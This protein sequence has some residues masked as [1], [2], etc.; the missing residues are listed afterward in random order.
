[1]AGWAGFHPR[2]WKK[3]SKVQSRVDPAPK[4]QTTQTETCTASE[5][6]Q[7][8]KKQRSWLLNT[9]FSLF[10]SL[11]AGISKDAGTDRLIACLEQ[12]KKQPA[13]LSL[14]GTRAK[15]T[16]FL[17]PKSPANTSDQVSLTSLGQTPWI[18]PFGNA[19][20]IF[21]LFSQFLMIQRNTSLILLFSQHEGKVESA[22]WEGSSLLKRSSISRLKLF[23]R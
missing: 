19:S 16:A 7:V 22:I 2:M 5:L 13:C 21:T 11:N 18:Q 14:S 10:L 17:P 20:C 4:S 15:P 23:N 9:L 3:T 12:C 8:F 1:M 6:T